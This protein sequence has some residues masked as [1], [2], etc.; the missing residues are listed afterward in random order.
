[1]SIESIQHYTYKNEFSLSSVKFNNYCTIINPEHINEYT[2]YWIKKGS[3]TFKIDFE[4]FDFKDN[5]LLFLSPNQFFSITSEKIDEAYKLIFNKDFYCIETHDKEIACNGSL[6]NNVYEIP[7]VKP[8]KND[9]LK[10]DFIIQNLIEEFSNEKTAQ[11]DMLKSYLKQFLIYAARIQKEHNSIKDDFETNLFRNFS[12]L[13]EQNYKKLHSIS[14]YAN[15][16]GISP[17]SLTKHFQLIGTSSP[18]TFLKNRILL[19]AKRKLLYSDE[20]VKEIAFEL[21]FNDPAYF[22]RFFKKS[23]QLS[24]L[25]FKKTLQN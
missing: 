18:S 11:Y 7:F 15:R 10:L 23:T 3:G 22:N 17:K 8:C 21:G 25:E 5:V 14:D 20:P 2:I 19:E 16:L 6:F 1:M 12:V 9:T 24:P 13:V 4:S